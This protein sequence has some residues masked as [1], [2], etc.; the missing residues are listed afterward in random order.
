MLMNNLSVLSLSIFFAA[1][2]PCQMS[3]MTVREKC[4]S[5]LDNYTLSVLRVYSY[6]EIYARVSL[7][8]SQ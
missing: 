5:Y 2:W 8:P 1:M 7:I 6:C 3:V 4:C